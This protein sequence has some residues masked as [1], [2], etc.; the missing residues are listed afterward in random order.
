LEAD[1]KDR[2]KK[3]SFRPTFPVHFYAT[4][5]TVE[6]WLLADER[7]LGK[8]ALGRGR[9]RS[10]KSVNTLLEEIIDPKTL[11]LKMLSE[12]DL[13]ADD[14]VNADIAYEADLVRIAERCPHFYEFRELV[15]A[16]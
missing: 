6:T 13:S 7:A 14:K 10:I 12:A 3:S 16:C 11:F 8:V 1:L 9:T 2:L 4:R 5:R 15:H